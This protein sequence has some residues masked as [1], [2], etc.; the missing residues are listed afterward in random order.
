MVIDLRGRSQVTDFFVIATASNPRLRRAVTEAIRYAAD[1]IGA[2][3]FGAEGEGDA[4]WA[5]L[6]FVDVIV[7][8]FDSEWRELYDLELLWGDAPHVPWQEQTDA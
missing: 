4:C 3:V 8:I 1:D 2:H 7:H 6:D 5:L